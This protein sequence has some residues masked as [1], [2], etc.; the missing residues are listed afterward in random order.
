MLE[1]QKLNNLYDVISVVPNVTDEI[2]V[3][4]FTV[5]GINP[6]NLSGGGNSFLTSV[7]VDGAPLPM[8]EIQQ[9]TFLPEM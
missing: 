1:E 2:G 6:F 9:G 5:R 8:R 7:Y 4:D 3:G